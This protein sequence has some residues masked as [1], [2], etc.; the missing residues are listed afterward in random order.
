MKKSKYVNLKI[1]K[2]SFCCVKYSH[3]RPGDQPYFVADTSWTNHH[4]LLWN[5]KVN[6]DQGIQR[7][8]DWIQC[9]KNQ[10]ERIADTILSIK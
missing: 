1:T 3:T 2:K 10:I 9:N 5:P 8:I 6:V 4:R 7:M